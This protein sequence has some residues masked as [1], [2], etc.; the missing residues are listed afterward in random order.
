MAFL[1]LHLLKELSIIGSQL[2]YLSANTFLGIGA[3]IYLNLSS[4]HIE[5]IGHGTFNNL[6]YV[7]TLDLR[8]NNLQLKQNM[9]QG[10]SSLRVLYVD[11][12]T[13]CCA[14]PGS[15]TD[16]NCFAPRDSIS[17]CTDLIRLSVLRVALWIIG[18]CAVLGNLFVLVYRFKY[19]QANLKKSYS[20]FVINLGLSDILMGIYMIIIGIADAVYRDRYVWEENDWRRSTTCTVSGILSTISSEASAFTILFITLDRTMAIAFP[21][22]LR[23][24]TM[25]SALITSVILW[26]ISIV[27]A[28]L[29][30]FTFTDYFRGEFYSSS[31]VCIALPLSDYTTPGSEYSVAIYVGLNFVIFIMIAVCQFV[32]YRK[33]RTNLTL[34]KTTSKQN[35]DITVAKGLAAVVATDF[36]CWFPICVL[37][38]WTSLGGRL[39]GDTYAWVMVLVLPINSALNPFLYTF[40]NTWR[41]RKTHH[42]QHSKYGREKSEAEMTNVVLEVLNTFRHKRGSKSLT[43]YL[44]DSETDLQVKNAFNIVHHLSACLVYLHK[45]ELV[46]GNISAESIEISL[47][48]DRVTD[49]VFP[50]DHHQV[51]HDFGQLNDIY[52]LG[53]VV[54]VLLKKIKLP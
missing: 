13:L 4:N 14:K 11:S 26:I 22:S 47:E 54:K 31:G 45:Q 39:S 33:S 25:K 2:R 15:V 50:M 3:L 27:I 19:D 18:L 7:K 42:R 30:V 12:Y 41:N 21:F 6:A 20:V 9:F 44:C 32:I 34:R 49:A 37:G 35:K 53:M 16:P 51:P 10:L 43:E 1:G 40:A 28:V 46:H 24:F 38:I 36:F 8:N 23:Q 29:P 17:S 5:N 52:D 48:N